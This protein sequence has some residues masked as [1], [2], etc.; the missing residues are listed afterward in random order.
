VTT[1]VNMPDPLM[2]CNRARRAFHLSAYTKHGDEGRSSPLDVF[3]LSL[4]L[5]LS[6]LLYSASPARFDSTKNTFNIRCVTF[7]HSTSPSFD[8]NKLVTNHGT[9]II[10]SP[11]RRQNRV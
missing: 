2:P 9:L 6:L 10:T 4:F 8:H 1:L 5:P 7:K 3:S 11:R